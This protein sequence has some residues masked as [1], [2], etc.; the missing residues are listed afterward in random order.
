MLAANP[1]NSGE[2]GEQLMRATSP[3]LTTFSALV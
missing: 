3:V 1:L 2:I